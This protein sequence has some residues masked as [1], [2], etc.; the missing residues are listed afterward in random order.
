[1]STFTY[2]DYQAAVAAAQNNENNN[3]PKIG[4][5][6]LKNDGDIAIARFN[7]AKA[8]ELMFASVHGLN[9]VEIGGN[10]YP[11]VSCLNPIGNF[12]RCA[13]CE[14]AARQGSNVGKSVKRV[15]V[16]MLVS[17]R[18]PNAANGYST[19]VPVIWERP[20]GFARE[21]ANKLAITGDLRSTLVLITR[22]GKAGDMQTTYSVDIL[23]ATHPVFK[24][25][26][27]PADF[28]AF[29]NFKINRHSYWEKTAEEINTFITTGAFPAQTQ[30]GQ[31]AAASAPTYNQQAYAAPVTPPAAQPQVA[32]SFNGFNTATTTP[33]VTPQ[34]AAPVAPPAPVTEPA[35][36][37]G[38]LPRNF[39]GFSF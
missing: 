11:K 29:D 6:R 7:I 32:P 20:A 25:E 13:L 12:G 35:N 22:N 33:P 30:A 15:Y 18:D 16:P 28:S 27:I 38:E 26:M 10:R 37:M 3:S 23:P 4:Y 9:N 21:L 17:Y 5:F 34:V 31:T 1:M 36:T 14:A 39:S 19:P 2:N 8:D 24:P